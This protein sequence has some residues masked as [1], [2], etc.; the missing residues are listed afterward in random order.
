M[1]LAW[2]REQARR[3]AAR[4][5]RA[6]LNRLIGADCSDSVVG[7]HWS[8]EKGT[9]REMPKFLFEADYSVEGTKGLIKEGGTKRRAVVDAAVK[10]VGG[11]VEAFYYTWGTRDAIVIADLPD[12]TAA[13][14]LS[15]NV[16]ASGSVAF[17]TTPLV[18]P[19]EIDQATKK[20]VSY[21]APGK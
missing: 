11:K 3:H 15:L 4:A 8:G 2:Y 19:E 21:K 17:K 9:G 16:S 5:T 7:P 18:T 1:T 14:T 6:T 12:A 10:S 13:I 20:R